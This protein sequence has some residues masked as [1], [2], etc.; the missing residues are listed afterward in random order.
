MT[1]SLRRR[2][3]RKLKG[4]PQKQ[5]AKKKETLATLSTKRVFSLLAKSDLSETELKV[6]MLL[7]STIEGK[8]HWTAPISYQYI[9][10]YI[11]KGRTSVGKAVKS[12]KEKGWL[13]VRP[14]GYGTASEY[15]IT[16]PH[17]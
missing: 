12:L 16:I 9:Q 4:V 10:D 3:K 13:E 1:E 11:G 2:T 6:I 8:S 15:K 17:Q 14:G 5:E 7:H